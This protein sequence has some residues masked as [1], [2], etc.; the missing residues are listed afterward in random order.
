MGLLSRKWHFETA[1]LLRN[2]KQFLKNWQ[3]SDVDWDLPH[4]Y[5]QLICLAQLMWMHLFEF[6]LLVIYCVHIDINK[7]GSTSRHGKH[8][9]KHNCNTQHIWSVELVLTWHLKLKLNSVSVKYKVQGKVYN[10]SSTKYRL[11]GVHLSELNSE[12][13]LFGSWSE[14]SSNWDW[15]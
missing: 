15:H 7:G 4:I 9:N 1:S 2:G 3:L 6:T 8:V 11:N 12:S 5:T 13:L 14:L 10:N